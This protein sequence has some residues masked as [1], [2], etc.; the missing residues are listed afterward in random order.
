MGSMSSGDEC[1][2][3]NVAGVVMGAGGGRNGEIRDGFVEKVA[4]KEKGRAQA[5]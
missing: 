1:S 3:E 2:G 5:M 4:F